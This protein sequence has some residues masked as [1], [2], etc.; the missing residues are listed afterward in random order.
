MIDRLLNLPLD[1]IKACTTYDAKSKKHIC[2]VC[3]REFEE[4]E[5][6]EAGGRYYDAIKAASVHVEREHISALHTLTS[7]DKKYTGLTE[8]QRELLLLK[9]DG[10]VRQG[11]ISIKTGTA[12]ATVRPQRFHVPRKSQAGQ[13]YLACL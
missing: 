7:F 9:Y 5:M 4:G 1:D 11:N 10:L 3:G 12:Q 13:L 6:F 8:N 2:F